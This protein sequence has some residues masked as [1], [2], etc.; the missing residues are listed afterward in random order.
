MTIM[1]WFRSVMQRVLDSPG[2]AFWTLV[3]AYLVLRY[4]GSWMLEMLP[5]EALPK[6]A[7]RVTQ[8]THSL[9]PRRGARTASQR[10]RGD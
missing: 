3:V 7:E 10:R 6:R 4:W 1:D 9:V 8:P 2:Q 5:Y